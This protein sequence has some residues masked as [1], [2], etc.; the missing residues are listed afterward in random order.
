MAIAI[1]I[2]GTKH[3]FETEKDAQKALRKLAREQRAKAE[4]ERAD[5]E[6]ANNRAAASCFHLVD[7]ACC[8][9]DDQSMR[10]FYAYSPDSS[11]YGRRSYHRHVRRDGR[12]TI[13][14]CETEHGTADLSIYGYEAIAIMENG[15]GY[16]I[17]ARL[18]DLDIPSREY[19]VSFGVCENQAVLRD[20]PPRLSALIDS[21]VED[22]TRRKLESSPD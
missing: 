11:D 6:I 13:I 19:W 1:E 14:R 4:K 16:I 22:R 8:V 9:L 15:P 3:E 7:A 20:I 5:R 12:E 21:A 10:V 2:N 18:R 17:G